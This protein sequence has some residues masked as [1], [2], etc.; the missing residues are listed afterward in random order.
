MALLY[1]GDAPVVILYT[2]TGDLESPIYWWVE[3][4]DGSWTKIIAKDLA[5][6]ARRNTK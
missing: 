6:A 2:W 5:T 4:E 1:I 3:E